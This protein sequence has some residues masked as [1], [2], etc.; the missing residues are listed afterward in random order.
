MKTHE[1]IRF[2]AIAGAA[3]FGLVLSVADVQA[4]PKVQ[5]SAQHQPTAAKLTDA[6]RKTADE[7]RSE[8]KQLDISSARV[9]SGSPDGR[10]RV[11][12]TIARR[13]NVPEKVVNDLRA[14][15]LGYGEVTI[16]LA[17]SQQLMKRGM[18]QQQ[19]IDR[20]IGLR[21]SGRGWGVVARDLGLKLGDVVSDVKKTDRQ[22]AKLDVGKPAGAE[23]PDTL[24]KVEKPGKPEKV[25]KPERP[26]R[27]E[28]PE[29]VDKAR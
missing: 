18:T 28:K 22:L 2:W 16:T 15:R 9:M 6:E 26:A 12:E 8:Q 24:A 1:P 21:T 29:K 27:P 11:S 20:V 14:R 3:A 13:F 4:Q 23:K 10:Q 7:L 19:A 17:L 5:G 25:E